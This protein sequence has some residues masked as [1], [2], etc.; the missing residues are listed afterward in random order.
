MLL[1]DKT[2][3]PLR[4]GSVNACPCS[5]LPRQW[6]QCARKYKHVDDAF[7]RGEKKNGRQCKRGTGN[8]NKRKGPCSSHE[9][10]SVAR[11]PNVLL[12]ATEQQSECGPNC[13][14]LPLPL[15]HSGSPHRVDLPLGSAGPTSP[16]ASSVPSSAL[17]KSRRADTTIHSLTP[18]CGSWTGTRRS[19]TSAA[20]KSSLPA[21]RAR[22]TWWTKGWRSEGCRARFC[23]GSTSARGSAATGRPGAPT[24]R[25]P[26]TEATGSRYPASGRSRNFH[27]QRGGF[28][29]GS[30][31]PGCSPERG[32]NRGRLPSGCQTASCRSPTHRPLPC[33]AV[34]S[35]PSTPRASRASCT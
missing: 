21:A 26:C 17:P 35:P 33:A 14:L 20:C 25:S 4:S 6:T 28:A 2:F 29:R 16:S 18:R 27:C 9:P 8:V 34:G 31:R 11:H 3:P 30:L 10:R 7:A 15:S 13:H 1:R 12:H 24:L 5:F 22:R 32:S 19:R 23:A